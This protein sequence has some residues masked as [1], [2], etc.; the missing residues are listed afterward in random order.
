MKETKEMTR[1]LIFGGKTGWIGGMMHD[2]CKEKGTTDWIF[3]DTASL[4]CTCLFRE[5]RTA[6]THSKAQL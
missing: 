2:L 4:D 6:D 3:K 1:V 5:A